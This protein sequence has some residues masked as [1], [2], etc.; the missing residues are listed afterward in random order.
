MAGDGQLKAVPGGTYT[1]PNASDT[2]DTPQL[3]RL[4]LSHSTTSYQQ[5]QE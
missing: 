5:E 3:S 4:S 2:E 1:V